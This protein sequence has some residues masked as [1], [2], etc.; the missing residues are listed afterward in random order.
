MCDR[1]IVMRE[2]WVTGE[3]TGEE[4]TEE[5][6]MHMATMMSREEIIKNGNN[7]KET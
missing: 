2:G 3:L 6:I 5:A 4:I 1:V 7:N